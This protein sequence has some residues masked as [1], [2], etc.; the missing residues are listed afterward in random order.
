MIRGKDWQHT[1]YKRS[2]CA[3]CQ[4]RS[5]LAGQLA[6]W[7]RQKLIACDIH[8][9]TCTHG[10]PLNLLAGQLQLAD[11][12][13]DQLAAEL[14]GQMA[15]QTATAGQLASYVVGSIYKTTFLASCRKPL[16]INSCFDSMSFAARRCLFFLQ[17]KKFLQ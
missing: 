14:P 1:M 13:A 16:G 10:Q 5:Q 8:K 9:S 6:S 7:A 3:H 4:P 17:M 12:L 15:A 2:R 11:Q